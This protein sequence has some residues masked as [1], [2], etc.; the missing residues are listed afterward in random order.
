MT[1]LA[2]NVGEAV[3][4]YR[5]ERGLTQ[6]E[7]AATLGWPQSSVARLERGAHEPT[8]PVLRHVAG[9]LRIAIRVVLDGDTVDV[10]I[11][12]PRRSRRATA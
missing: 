7:L 12:K 8:I 5:R 9:R 6:L 11:R 10:Q 1:G 3:R 4:A 2:A